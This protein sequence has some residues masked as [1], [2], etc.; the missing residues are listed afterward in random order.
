MALRSTVSFDTSKYSA[1]FAKLNQ[2][3]FATMHNY[4]AAQS[5]T[6]EGVA[7]HGEMAE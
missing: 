1:A 6:V 4:R 5:R 3:P 7:Y 2:T